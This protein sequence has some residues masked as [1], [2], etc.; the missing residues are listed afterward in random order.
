MNRHSVQSICRW[1]LLLLIVATSTLALLF[2]RDF[3][4]T[5]VFMVP[6]V[7]YSL[8]GFVV[9]T[10][11]PE[12]AI[13]W[14]FLLVGL[15]GGLINLVNVGNDAAQAIEQLVPG[16]P[17][18]WWVVVTAWGFDLFWFPTLTLVTTFS[19]LL[20]PSGLPTRRWRPILWLSV[21]STVL[22][23]LLLALNPTLDLGDEQD[24]VV[25]K[26]DN[27]LSPR[28]AEGIG[29][30]ALF[31]QVLIAVCIFCFVAS[32][33]AVVVRTWRSRG[34]ERQQMRIFAFAV[35][36]FPLQNILA[37]LTNDFGN[38]AV[39]ELTFTIVM[40]CMPIACGLA[41]LRYRLYDIDRI[42]GRTTAYAI[43]TGLLIG[44]YALVVTSVTRLLPGTSSSLAVATATLAAAAL[45]RP[46]HSRVQS[47]VDR[48]FNRSRYDAQR[49]IEAFA[50]R[51]R[52]EVTPDS[53]T[54]DLLAVLQTTVQ[55]SGAALWLKAGAP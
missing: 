45:F 18:T 40:T 48:R 8:V 26:V 29:A 23:T 14:I 13:G 34:V 21:G 38:P 37:A 30:D 31:V 49:T 25:L 27:P 20:F 46:V 3:A 51:L 52:D 2:A 47:F 10:R 50:G 15:F 54:A 43:V 36:L 16:Q 53:V 28:W 35:A 22:F 55:P 1:L 32:I 19:F 7:G 6:V 5:V 4:G 11:R 12:I 41:I 24:P 39:E 44:V 42:I 33:V 17:F 9:T